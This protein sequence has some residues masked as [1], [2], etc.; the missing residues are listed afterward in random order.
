VEIAVH[1][2][3]IPE[4]PPAVRQSCFWFVFV[5]TLTPVLFTFFAMVVVSAP[6]AIRP[7]PIVIVLTANI[8]AIAEIATNA[9]L[10]FFMLVI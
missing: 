2:P 5:C 9:V 7:F 6:N 4:L 1:E 10:W 8:A 3:E